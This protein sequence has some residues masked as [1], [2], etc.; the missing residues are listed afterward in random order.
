MLYNKK[1]DLSKTSDLVKKLQDLRDKALDKAIELKAKGY[2]VNKYII[3][4]DRYQK[5]IDQIWR[6]THGEFGE[7]SNLK[8]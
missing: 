8:P 5:T 7:Y 2:N 4:A 1:Y 3:T 6:A